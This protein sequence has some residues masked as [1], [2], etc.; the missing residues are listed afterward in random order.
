M[1]AFRAQSLRHA[2]Q[3]PAGRRPPRS[4]S[5]TSASGNGWSAASRSRRAR[6]SWSATRAPGR[7]ARPR[8]RRRGLWCKTDSAGPP[9]PGRHPRG[10]ARPRPPLL[11][12]AGVRDPARQG[13]GHPPRQDRRRGL[14]DRQAA[15]RGNLPRRRE[16]ISRHP[17][18]GPDPGALSHQQI[19]LSTSRSWTWMPAPSPATQ[20][21]AQGRGPDA[22]PAGLCRRGDQQGE[23]PGTG[24]DRGIQK[25]VLQPGIYFLNPEEKRIDIVS[26]GYAETSLMVEAQNRA[27]P[28]GRSP[29]GRGGA[30][31]ATGWAPRRP[32][33]R[34][35][36]GQG[37]RVSL[38]RRLP[39]PPRLHGD[40]GHP[41]RAGA[42]TSSASSAR[43]RTS[44]R[45]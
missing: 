15:S 42:R 35:T 17:P 29:G 39:D 18:Q 5:V 6:A 40:L 31:R 19:R 12:A 7:S 43:S 1:N 28:Q 10:H 23:R 26:I 2:G 25:Q 24:E 21:Q 13:R 37:D 36:P 14:Q 41:P 3:G 8:R 4:W 45:R 22:D 30:H 11:L 33:T 9:A 20:G 38:E 16:G 44:S 32:T 27:T 34:S